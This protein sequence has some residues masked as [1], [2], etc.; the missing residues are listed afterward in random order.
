M[1]LSSR[2]FRGRRGRSRPRPLVLS[3]ALAVLAAA[4]TVLAGFGAHGT[5]DRSGLPGDGGHDPAE[6]TVR[7]RTPGPSPLQAVDRGSPEA[8][9]E[10]LRRIRW[11]D[12]E[13]S[14]GSLVDGRLELELEVLRGVWHVLGDDE[15]NATVLAF[16]EAG[17]APRIP[18]P[19]IR[20]P[21]GTEIV[22]RVHNP[23]DAEL[24]IEG[25][26]SRRVSGV[27]T[28]SL[29][30]GESREVRFTADAEGSYMYRARLEDSP[31]AAEPFEDDLL[32]GAL[33]VDPGVPS[34]RRV[35]SRDSSP[36]EKVMVMQIWFGDETGEGEP[37]FAQE[38][39]VI[40][41]RPWPHTERLVYDMGDTIRWRVLNA[42]DAVHPMHLHG[43]FYRVEARGDL[44]RDSVY[45]RA[46]T[47]HA[48]TERMDPWT[49]MKLAW[50]PDRPGA[51]I[52]HCHNTAHVLPN[53]GLVGD[54]PGELDRFMH[55][56]RGGA[57]GDPHHHAE[58]A[59]GGL[60][61]G[62]YIRP[63]KGWS[64]AEPEDVDLHL[65]VQKDSTPDH[66]LPRFGFVIRTDGP[67]P[68]PDSVPFP[69]P[70]LVLHEGPPAKVRVVNRSG[71]PTQVHWHGLEVESY[72]D[73]VAGGTGYPDRRTPAILPGDS[74]DVSLR[75]DRPG[76]YIYHTHMSD[77][78]QQGAGL[79][80]PLI[81][82]PEGEE[83]D[84]ERDRIFIMGQG[85]GHGEDLE[86][87]VF[88]N[89]SPA[90]P[91]MTMKQGVRYRLRVI[92][93]TLFN[94]LLQTRLLRD[95][96]PVRW[97]PSAHDGW[98]L[99]EHQRDPRRAVQTV[100]VG[101]T[102]DFAFTPRRPGEMRFDVRSFGGD[103]FASQL[104]QVTGE[105]GTGDAESAPTDSTRG[106]SA[107]GD[108]ERRRVSRLPGSDPPP[109]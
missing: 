91:A 99:P 102:F 74:F 64:V 105:E 5:S 8:V 58:Q 36:P 53:P 70:P 60:V 30:P 71:E 62:V 21:Q 41:G 95:G 89:G 87:R 23:L 29:A 47:R 49:T 51:W 93:I 77:L 28:V 25:L 63:P 52:F 32:A 104:I 13:N 57:H 68:A 15:P 7:E 42:S 97:E 48:V 100:S 66:P 45:W 54:L 20:V 55:L 16:A 17:K 81:I 19:M 9:A 103:L 22:A 94:G 2:D 82:L 65:Y 46:E 90:P 34:G 14:A 43:F 18:G 79:Y 12:N 40:N 3:V 108:P 50:T 88:L 84:P 96:A 73:G 33:I 27:E 101:E 69:G 83:W 11:N 98:N 76:T 44:A 109:D 1:R 78:R 92:N 72:F 106:S 80:G 35:S 67:E 10:D 61:M 75:T 85:L 31:T 24:E 6:E 107:H 86:A 59:M 37:D 38:F 4:P 26:S 39:L 56:L